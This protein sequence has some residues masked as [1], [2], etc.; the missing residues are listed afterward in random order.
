MCGRNLPGFP[1][2]SQAFCR[3]QRAAADR[4]AAAASEGFDTVAAWWWLLCDDDDDSKLAITINHRLA[5][6]QKII[7]TMCSIAAT[8]D[9]QDVE[10]GLHVVI[11]T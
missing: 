11:F 10:I 2:L 6:H 8:T 7:G 4:A 3:H 1:H 5:S 9:F